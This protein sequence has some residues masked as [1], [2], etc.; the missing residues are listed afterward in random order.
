MS[1]AASTSIEDVAAASG[2]GERWFQ[3]YWPL[4]EHDEITKSILRR[5]KS[6]GFKVL[7]VTLDVSD[8]PSLLFYHAYWE[9]L[10]L[11]SRLA[12]V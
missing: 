11:H 3:L 12:T 4:K 2:E 8:L 6:N 9:S 1:T 10:D 7:V 5:A